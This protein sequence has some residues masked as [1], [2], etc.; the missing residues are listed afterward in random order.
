ME[1]GI[2]ILSGF[3]FNIRDVKDNVNKNGKFTEEYQKAGIKKFAICT[4]SDG[5]AKCEFIW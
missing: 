3:S 1:T 2:S 5:L 4:S